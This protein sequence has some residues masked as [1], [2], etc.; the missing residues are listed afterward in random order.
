MGSW[1]KHKRP[2]T[3]THELQCGLVLLYPFRSRLYCKIETLEIFP[4]YNLVS[5]VSKSSGVISMLLAVLSEG[6]SEFVGVWV[7]Y[8]INDNS[9]KPD[10]IM[11]E[12]ALDDWRKFNVIMTCSWRHMQI[13][14]I[15]TISA[16]HCAYMWSTNSISFHPK[17]MATVSL[18]LLLAHFGAKMMT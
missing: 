3:Q 7:K 9:P 4:L 15:S 17:V 2:K 16:D 8:E 18:V 5:R 12:P 6:G 14:P 13:S 1:T 11:Q 10:S